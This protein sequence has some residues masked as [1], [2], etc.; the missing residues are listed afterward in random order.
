MMRR[1]S[2][3]MIAALACAL[4]LSAC[5]SSDALEGKDAAGV[6]EETFG[7]DHPVRSGRL[8]VAVR[9]NATGLEG[10][11]GP[12]AARLS[13][14]FQSKG[15]KSL[16]AL[17]LKLTLDAGGDA[18]TAGI[19]STGEKGFLTIADQSYDVGDDLYKSLQDSYD[20][21][22]T[23]GEKD[24]GPTFSTLGIKPLRW[25]KG[26]KTAGEEDIGGTTAVHVTADVDVAKL[27]EDIDTL[28][29]KAGDVAVPGT[30]EKVPTGLTAAQRKAIVD[31]VKTAGF[32]VWAGKQDGTLRRL[33]AEVAFDVPAAARKDAGGLEKGAFT[34][35]LTISSLNEDQEVKAPSGAR[36]ISELTASLQG[37]A[38]GGSGS[39][40][41]TAAQPSVG[42]GSSDSGG[43]AQSDYTD[44]LAAA[45]QD[46]KKVQA[47][48]G[49]LGQ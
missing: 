11:E 10:L 39:G 32:D 35:D 29:S 34:V 18:F 41:G 43:G 30:D 22:S 25:L 6:L 9:F 15:G 1:L 20:Q 46:L 42:A 31:S 37:G 21:A 13:G 26:P 7:P 17:D 44:C 12:I 8:E 5:G 23:E 19:V 24:S 14:P 45:G 48:A 2:L 27:L 4:A 47:C 28:L 36:P 49:L 3:L 33:R 16:P 38:S 40:D